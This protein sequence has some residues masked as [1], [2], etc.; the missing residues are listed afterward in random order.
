M[1]IAV[2]RQITVWETLIQREDSDV[3]GSAVQISVWQTLIQRE[4]GDV[5]GSVAI[6]YSVADPNSERRQ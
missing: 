5:D 4:G 2:W 3:D 1:Q 6:D